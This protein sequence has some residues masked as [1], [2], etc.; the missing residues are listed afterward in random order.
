[1]FNAYAKA[2]NKA[3]QR[4]GPVFERPFKRIPVTD[5]KYFMRLL[6][7]VHQNPRRHELID[8]FQD[9][10]YSSYGVLIGDQP[11]FIRRDVV[12]QWFGDITELI[13]QDLNGFEAPGLEGVE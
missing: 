11:T 7:Y 6:I 9:W 4:T 10:P 8:D 3:Y 2:I 13:N 5:S 1:L 12:R